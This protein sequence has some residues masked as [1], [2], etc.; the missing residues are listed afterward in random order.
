MSKQVDT[1]K[2]AMIGCG[3]VGSASA[4][5]L[6]QSGLFSEL[7]LIDAN[8]DKAE[9]EAMDIAHGL[10]FAGQMKIYAGDY[11]DIV[12]EAV[13]IVTAGAAQKPGETRLDLVNKNVN[14]F[15]SIIP[16]I[17]KRNYKGILLIVANPVDIL[18]YTAV[19]LSGLP[20]NR[21]IGSG[22]VLDTARL[23]YALG[24]HLEVDSR[25]VHSFIIGE[26]G[27]SEIVAWSSTNVSG[28]PVNDF[29][30]L[31]G[32]FNHEEA[33]HRIADDVK[34]S[35]YDIIEKKG[36]TYYDIAMSVKR[37]C[38]CIMRDEKSILPISS[39]MHGEYGISDICLSMPTVV[40]REGVETRVPIQLN[41]QEESALS[42]SAEQ[43]SKVAAQLDLS[44]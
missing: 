20:E 14:I 11:D 2:A 5:A 16:E 6:M 22:T 29:C 8:H 24:E 35:A 39:M 12:D 43:L 25:S 41:E 38:E 40:G 44:L 26:H 36:A 13:I 34:N 27:D 10:P 19:K 33:M 1:R 4:F 30:E 17:A 18:T 15:K 21:V 37:I 23:K 3:F 32:H 7:V 28:I 31:R 42:A 9:G